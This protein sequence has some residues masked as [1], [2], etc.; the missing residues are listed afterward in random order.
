MELQDIL[1]LDNELMKVYKAKNLIKH[2]DN[3][4]FIADRKFLAHLHKT[5]AEYFL[6]IWSSP[7][8]KPL[9]YQTITLPKS[10]DSDKQLSI[11]KPIIDNYEIL[12]DRHCPIQPIQYESF[13]THVK[14]RYNLR[15]LALLPYHLVNA[16]MIKEIFECVFFNIEWIYAKIK[17]FD[18]FSVLYDYDLLKSDPEVNLVCESLKMSESAIIEDPNLLFSQLIGRLL[19]YYQIFPKVQAFV[20]EC[21]AKSSIINP[22]IPVGQIFESPA[23]LYQSTIDMGIDSIENIQLELV[24]SDF[25]GQI[26]VYK[27]LLNPMTKF[28][29]MNLQDF[30]YEIYNGKGKIYCNKSGDFVCIIENN[31]KLIIRRIESGEFYG[32]VEFEPCE[33]AHVVL[34]SKFICFILRKIPSPLIIDLNTST[35]IKTLP[36]PTC[37]CAISPDDTVIVVHSE[38]S[39]NYHSIPSFDRLITLDSAEIPEKVIFANNNRKLFVL[40]KD[41]KQITFFKLI[42]EKK[43]KTSEHV[44]QDPNIFDMMVSSDESMLIVCALYCVYVI[45]VKDSINIKFK[46]NLNEVES[47]INLDPKLADDS[48]ASFNSKSQSKNTFT[49]F[50]CTR[51]Q[52]V[53]YATMYTYLVCYDTNSGQLLRVFQSTLSANRIIKTISSRL[54]DLVVSLLDNGKILIWNLEAIDYKDIKFEDQRIFNSKIDACSSPQI[55][56]NSSKNSNL[57]LVYSG[58]YPDAK[59]LHSKRN[60]YSKSVVKTCYFEKN[61]NPFTSQIKLACLDDNGKFCFMVTDVQDFNGKKYPEEEGFYKKIC[62]IIDLGN[63]NRVID[64]FSYV[65]RKNSR[66][67]INGKFLAKKNGTIDETYLII[68]QVSGLNDFDAYSSQNL[69]WTEFETCIKIMGPINSH[70]SKVELFDEFKLNGDSLESNLCINK[71]AVFA[72]LVQECSKLYDKQVAGLIKAK[73]VDVHLDVYD[74]FQSKEKNLK[75]QVFSLSEFL[76]SEENLGGKNVF[77]DIRVLGDQNFFLVYSKN[78]FGKDDLNHFEFDLESLKFKRDIKGEKAAF[79]YD[80]HRNQVVKKFSSIF[81]S[82]IDVE[83]V[84]FSQG[85]FVMDNQ[86]NLYDLKKNSLVKN[87]RDIWLKFDFSFVI[88][89]S[90]GR[91]FLTCTEE[92]RKILLIRCYDSVLVASVRLADEISCLS[93]GENERTILIGTVNGYVWPLKL[94]I[95]LENNEAINSYIRFYRNVQEYLSPSSSSFDSK[96]ADLKNDL[97]RVS[98]SAHAHRALKTI[99]SKQAF[100]T[101]KNSYTSSNYS[102][103]ESDFHS[104]LSKLSLTQI[105][106]TQF[107]R[108]F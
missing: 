49:G 4:P 66:L 100:M 13:H 83:R 54:Q 45:Q 34:S 63:E 90:N 6:G 32:S 27:K 87:F 101:T 94:V 84:V 39:L 61:D 12:V 98:H 26:L 76:S 20:D 7:V 25:N 99:E 29:D 74:L 43:I 68:R 19:P 106:I 107:P 50:G 72:S 3:K 24:E 81:N 82:E 28:F 65:A 85:D 95:D 8:Q 9:K 23:W 73:R 56:H 91:Y 92:R 108:I 38:N 79:I 70:V 44:L 31:S 67:E 10:D 55:G 102:K 103:L 96:S 51:N 105:S 11:G 93:I 64:E 30:K 57:C 21:D 58:A 41:T 1:S 88:F 36:Y 60:F 42:L 14:P 62:S 15:K 46:I 52:T 77:I 37:F 18:L 33:I 2:T 69:D 71:T 40:S 80:P 104:G 97:K 59:T 47:Y 75:V 86:L 22:L 53:V 48:L 16:N 35:L 78:G 5:V 89:I 17:A